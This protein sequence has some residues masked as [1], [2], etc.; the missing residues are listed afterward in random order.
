M[1]NGQAPLVNPVHRARTWFAL[2]VVIFGIFAVRLFYLQIIRYDYYTTAARTSQLKEAEVHAARG[3]I[4]A[5]M[6]DTVVPLVLNQKLY[7]LYADPTLIKHADQTAEKLASVLGSK[8]ADLQKLLSTKNTRYVV[9]RKKLTSDQ[10]TKILAFKLPGVGTQEQD[11]RTYPQGAM[12][13]QVLGF[14]NDEGTGEYGLE[15]ALNKELKGTPGQLKAVT[16]VNGV[17]LAASSDNL[18]IAPVAG[19]DVVLTIDMGMQLQMEQILARD[20][21]KLKAKG[22][23]AVIVDPNT[24]AIKAMANVPSFDPAH[25]QETEDPSVFQNAAI[26]NAI[27]PGSIIKVLTAAA[28]LDQ[29]VVQPDTT[30]YDPA[31]WLIDG[32]TI[33]DIEEDGGARTQSIAS[34]LNLSLNT[35]ATWLLMQMGGGEVNRKAR[36]TW[37]GYMTDRFQFGKETGVEQGYESTGLVPKPENNGAGIN[38]TYAN[39]SFGQ[40]MQ[41]TTLQMAAALSGVVNGGTYYRPYL[42]D[43]TIDSTGKGTTTSPKIVKE[44]VVSKQV[45]D[46]IIP[47]MEYVVTEHYK[48]GATYLNFGPNYS[49]GGKTGTAQIAKPGGGYYDDEFN[50]TYMGFVGGDHPQYVIAI[51]TIQ[52]Q[53]AGYAGSQAGQPLFADLAHMLIQNFDVTPRTH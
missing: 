3:T 35:G 27:E 53:V 42:V 10:S 46:E 4:S 30:F 41:T 25:Y 16:D 14:V 32:F 5:H 19:K 28:A 38:L 39:T 34:T 51:F 13:A 40:A 43:Q 45:S 9:I 33:R 31:R 47:L 17:P 2:L 36:D 26:T 44:G 21:Q 20:Q 6:G 7:T 37:Y 23:S 18:S 12:A 22:L 1:N 15:Q 49:V 8:E 11:Y 52:P 29:G 24:G 50:G 48:A